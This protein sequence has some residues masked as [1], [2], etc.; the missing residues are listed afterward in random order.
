MI[1]LFFML[2]SFPFKRQSKGEVTRMQRHQIKS[3]LLNYVGKSGNISDYAE[4]C[5][6]VS[7]GTSFRWAYPLREYL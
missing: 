4:A 3:V 6:I 2:C 7:I 5:R 1:V